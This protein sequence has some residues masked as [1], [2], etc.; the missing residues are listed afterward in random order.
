MRARQTTFQLIRRSSSGASFLQ[1]K[2]ALARLPNEPTNEEKLQLYALYKQGTTG[3]PQGSRPGFLDPVGRA[4]FDAWDKVKSMA[5]EEAQNSYVSLVIKLNDG[6]ALTASE[7]TSSSSTTTPSLLELQMSPRQ[8]GVV[9][10]LKLETISTILSPSG[11]LTARL[12][13]PNRGNAFNMQMWA[14]WNSL[15]AAVNKDSETRVVVVTG[16]EASFSTGMDL[17][18]FSQMQ[19]LAEKEQCQAR[20]REA[21]AHVIDY[22]SSSVSLSE[23][24]RVPVLAAISGSC[25]GG[26]VDIATACDL[27]FCTENTVFS[28]KEIDLAIVADIGTLQRLPKLIG[29]QRARDLSY[30]GRNVS[31]KEA[32]EM[33]L[34]LAPPF[35]TEAEMLK[36]VHDKAE[37]IASKSPLTIRGIKSSLNFSR[38]HSVAEGLDH[39]KMHNAA[40][41]Y[42]SDLLTAMTGGK[43]FKG[44]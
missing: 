38:D 14:D 16:S 23:T 42:S 10:A 9:S 20:K 17:S 22:F 43:T 35:K 2:E 15:F 18:V 6:K 8:P 30:T 33:G 27:R 34:V 44:V 12:N 13:R 4:K 41:L 36:A 26:A 25:I 31:G 24:C 5:K 40:F 7:P 37:V 11:I 19:A 21:L 32:F 3:P 29:E 1:A 28:V 39:V